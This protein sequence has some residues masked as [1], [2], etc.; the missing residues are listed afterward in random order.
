MKRIK[1][2]VRILGLPGLVAWQIEKGRATLG[3]LGESGAD[4]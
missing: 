2:L 3:S 1:L 4:R